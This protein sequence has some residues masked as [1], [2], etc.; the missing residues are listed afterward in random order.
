MPVAAGMSMRFGDVT[1]EITWPANGIAPR[2]NN[3]RSIVV[4]LRIPGLSALLPGTK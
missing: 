4:D 1:A 2:E 3:D